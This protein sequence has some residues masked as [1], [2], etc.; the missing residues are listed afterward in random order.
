MM[1]TNKRWS[2]AEFSILKKYLDSRKTSFQ[3]YLECKK[4][5]LDRSFDSV[6][7]KIKRIKREAAIK[8]YGLDAIIKNNGVLEKRY[9][10]GYLDIESTSLDPYGEILT[11]AIKERDG[12]IFHDQI[13]NLQEIKNDN[14]R[15]L[16]ESLCAKIS[17]FDYLYTFYG[18]DYHFDLPMIRTKAIYYGIDFP[19][20]GRVYQSDLWSI[21][22]RKLRMRRYS[23]A[24][25]CDYFG[26]KGKT[27]L[28][29]KIW[30]RAKYGDKEAL[31]Q[32]LEHNIGDVKITEEL[33]K[34]IETHFNN[35]KSSI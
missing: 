21:A 30:T 5:G 29:H 10:I 23:L 35:T 13:K 28:N 16:I 7:G 32:V 27:P 34:K 24:A 8:I 33:H 15:R 31:D 22:K 14:D 9:R 18:G 20:Y 2:E 6:D 1:D 19:G 25:I 3:V 4:D 26:I 11:W 17:E 12:E